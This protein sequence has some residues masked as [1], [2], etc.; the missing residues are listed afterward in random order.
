[1]GKTMQKAKSLIAFWYAS[2]YTLLSISP[3]FR[4]TPR[5]VRASLAEGYLL[6]SGVEVQRYNFFKQ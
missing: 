1:M 4:S 6:Q 3:A 5:C 2:I